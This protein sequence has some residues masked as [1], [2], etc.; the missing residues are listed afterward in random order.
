M[1]ALLIGP[2]S[3]TAQIRHKK[4][5]LCLLVWDQGLLQEMVALLIGPGSV[6]RLRTH[7]RQQGILRNGGLDAWGPKISS[8]V[9]VVSTVV[10]PQKSAQKH[11]PQEA[12]F[13]NIPPSWG[14]P[15]L[16]NKNTFVKR[17][18]GNLNA[19]VSHSTIPD[20]DPN[21][22]AHIYIYIYIYI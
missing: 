6:R 17:W 21:A 1:V 15:F 18:A 14:H 19:W 7:T 4:W 12:V 8:C 3:G 22:R 13:L 16:L 9:I 2:G 10:H 11:P 20:G 5:W